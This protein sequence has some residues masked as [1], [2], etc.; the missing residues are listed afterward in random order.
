MTKKTRVDATTLY[1]A[2]LSKASKPNADLA[3]VAE[4]L[5]KAMNLGS[6]EATYALATWYLFGKHF[7]KSYVKGCV[8]LRKAAS[9]GSR[10]AMFDLAVSYEGGL[11]VQ[12]SEKKAYEY[13]LGAALRGDG[14]AIFNVGRC[15][16]YG[17]GVPRDRRVARLW[18][19]RAS[20]LGVYESD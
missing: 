9:A 16:Y 8:L 6:V 5:T 13:F 2:A 20:E 1:E 10:D 12:K 4:I 17:I 19:D 3:S 14:K 18:L 15:T 11:G 7:R